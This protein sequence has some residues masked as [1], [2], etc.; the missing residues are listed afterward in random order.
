MDDEQQKTQEKTQARATDRPRSGM[1]TNDDDGRGKSETGSAAGDTL[2]QATTMMRNVGEQAWSAAASAGSAATDLARQTRDQMSETLSGP[3]ER[4]G[5]YISRNVNAYPLAA[6]IAGA[7][8]YGLG[9]LVHSSW[10]TQDN[11]GTRQKSD[12]G[13]TARADKR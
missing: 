5:E 9:Y 13:E 12:E 6:L 1:T 11:R 2:N 3:T 10:Q 8:G 7:V 4:A